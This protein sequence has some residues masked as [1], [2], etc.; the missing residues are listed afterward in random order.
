MLQKHP[1]TPFPSSTD[2]V[3]Y[4]A[5]E[6]SA[7]NQPISASPDD[8]L[9]PPCHHPVAQLTQPVCIRNGEGAQPR[10]LCHLSRDLMSLPR[11][12]RDAGSRHGSGVSFLAF[13]T[14]RQPSPAAP[15]GHRNTLSWLPLPAWRDKYAL[16]GCG[17]GGSLECAN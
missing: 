2:A 12:P 5:H 7:R 14:F 13:K 3:P 8:P 17:L 11:P 9:P 6:T 10:R 1:P 15:G 16:P 4:S